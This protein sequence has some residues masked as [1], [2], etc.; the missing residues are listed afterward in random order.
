MLHVHPDSGDHAPQTPEATPRGH[1]PV[2]PPQPRPCSLSL[3]QQWA[4]RG[5]RVGTRSFI[6]QNGD[7]CRRGAGAR[8]L[9]VGGGMAALG[10]EVPAGALTLH[11]LHRPRELWAPVGTVS[12]AKQQGGSLS[13][14]GSDKQSQGSEGREAGG[15][16]TGVAVVAGGGGGT[17]GSG[18]FGRAVPGAPGPGVWGVRRPAP[19]AWASAQLKHRWGERLRLP[20]PEGG[21]APPSLQ[22]LSGGPGPTHHQAP[23]TSAREACSPRPSSDALGP[24]RDPRPRDSCLS[25]V[26]LLAQRLLGSRAP[27]VD[28]SPA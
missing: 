18:V 9:G 20:S 2:R 3:S 6:A 26:C 8:G 22:P 1:G 14:P 24:A 23:S 4:R 11:R 19:A 10:W 15:S 16:R 7:G 21:P 12:P 27:E 28:S 5:Q 25:P 17:M 13:F